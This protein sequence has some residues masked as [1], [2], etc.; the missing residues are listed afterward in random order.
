MVFFS[1]VPFFPNF[2]LGFKR[3]FLG[4]YLF[5][6]AELFNYFWGRN[7]T[8]TIRD[9]LFPIYFCLA[10]DVSRVGVSNCFLYFK[11]GVRLNVWYE[12]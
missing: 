4:P 10:A 9:V 6:G 12:G 5:L 1:R 11:S 2:F 3:G 8:R 7:K